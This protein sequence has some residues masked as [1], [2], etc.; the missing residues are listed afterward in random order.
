MRLLLQED[1][2]TKPYA[3]LFRF[4][5]YIECSSAVSAVG[6]VAVCSVLNIPSEEACSATGVC[7]GNATQDTF[8]TFVP[9]DRVP[10]WVQHE[11]VWESTQTTGNALA[12]A[13]RTATQEQNDR[14]TYEAGWGRGFGK[15]PLVVHADPATIAKHGMGLNGTGLAPAIFAGGMEETTQCFPLDPGFCSGTGVTLQQKF[16]LYTTVFY[17]YAPPQGWTFTSGDGIPPAP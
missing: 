5:G 15:S 12:L 3:S 16:S 13:A 14:G 1:V 7:V 10:D 4:D 11:L 9:L 8:N 6:S 2:A 17:G